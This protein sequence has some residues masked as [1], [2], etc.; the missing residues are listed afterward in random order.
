[1]LMLAVLGF[2]L[3]AAGGHLILNLVF[4]YSYVK[5]IF[6]PDVFDSWLVALGILFGIMFIWYLVT[7]W[8]EKTEK[9]VILK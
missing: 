8:N 4:D 2:A 9:L 3:A 6:L 5:R 1:K 7:S